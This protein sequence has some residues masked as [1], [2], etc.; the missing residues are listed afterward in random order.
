MW[1][2]VI[3]F[4][5]KQKNKNASKYSKPHI[6][7]ACFY[8]EVGTL[9]ALPVALWTHRSSAQAPVF[10]LFS[11][12]RLGCPGRLRPGVRRAP[13]HWEP[14][15]K[16][17]RRVRKRRETP[18]LKTQVSFSVSLFTVG[19]RLLAGRDFPAA[20]RCCGAAGMRHRFP[21]LVKGLLFTA[22]GPPEKAPS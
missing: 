14:V 9:P 6:A 20:A 4:S 2:F 19:E 7:P 5:T 15:E 1:M 16:C 18:V 22:E 10:M 21:S 13:S 17:V 8:F 3:A 12:P 11:V